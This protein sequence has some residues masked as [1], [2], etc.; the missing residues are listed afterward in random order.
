LASLRCQVPRAPPPATAATPMPD[1]DPQGAVNRSLARRGIFALTPAT[2]WRTCGTCSR[3]AGETTVRPQC[4]IRRFRVLR[5]S[6]RLHGG[7]A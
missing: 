7:V 5:R 4:A 1:P 3:A 2:A 6:V